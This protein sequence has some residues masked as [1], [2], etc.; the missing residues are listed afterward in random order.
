MVGIFY[1]YKIRS[2]HT[3]WTIIS[4]HVFDFH[5]CV[6]YTV[7]IFENIHFLHQICHQQVHCL[8]YT[9]YATQYNK[10]YILSTFE[11]I[12]IFALSNIRFNKLSNDFHKYWSDTFENTSFTKCEFPFIFFIFYTLFCLLSQNKPGRQDVPFV[13]LG[14]IYPIIWTSIYIFISL[15]ALMSVHISIGTVDSRKTLLRRCVYPSNQSQIT[16]DVCEYR[17]YHW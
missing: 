14:H 5:K 2:F 7:I 13:V 17:A 3:T 10:R 8:P 9:T 16:L 1:F 4:L 15:C 12:E 6:L 11:K